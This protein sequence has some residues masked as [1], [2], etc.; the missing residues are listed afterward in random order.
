MTYISKMFKAP[1]EFHTAEDLMSLSGEFS[2]STF[3]KSI[4][5][6]DCVC[7]RS[8]AMSGDPIILRKRSHDGMTVAL[9]RKEFSIGFD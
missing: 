1:I 8:A 7:E 2:S 3:V 6:V 4:T 5:S 9:C